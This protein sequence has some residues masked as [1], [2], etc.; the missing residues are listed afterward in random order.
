[1]GYQQAIR[2]PLMRPSGSP[3]LGGALTPL[4]CRRLFD[5]FTAIGT[6][7]GGSTVGGNNASATTRRARMGLAAVPRA[8]RRWRASFPCPPPPTVSVARWSRATQCFVVARCRR[9]HPQRGIDGCHHGSQD[10]FLTKP[11]Y[12]VVVGNW[13]SSPNSGRWEFYRAGVLNRVITRLIRPGGP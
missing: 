11:D 12:S 9:D 2:R 5:R 10:S 1:M 8:R 7:G 4:S 6:R 13:G 3:A